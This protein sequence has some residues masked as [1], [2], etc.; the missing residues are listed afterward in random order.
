[1][2]LYLSVVIK[3]QIREQ[4]TIDASNLLAKP[5]NSVDSCV[6]EIPPGT[7]A[8]DVLTIQWPTIDEFQKFSSFRTGR[9]SRSS[10]SERRGLDINGTSSPV[11]SNGTNKDDTPELHV[12]FTIPPNFAIKKIKSQ[13]L[14][15]QAPWIST[16]RAAS[17]TLDSRQLRRIGIDTP[18]SRR[19]RRVEIRNWGEGNVK[20]KTCPIGSMYQV[21]ERSI[22]KAG[23]W[24]KLKNDEHDPEKVE[25][26]Q[27]W[28]RERGAEACHEDERID[29]YIDSLETFQ[30]DQFFVT[31]HQCNYN[32]DAAKQKMDCKTLQIETED[33]NT[34][35]TQKQKCDPARK[36]RHSIK[37]ST[38]IRN[39]FL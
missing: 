22:P 28:D 36:A 16:A 23:T 29:P 13:Y 4:D 30:K 33:G 19:S 15:L 5:S 35:E 26:D 37:P 11:K 31:L 32:F 6:V 24:A 17:A 3:K 25:C 20:R 7:K 21:S 27:M 14:R 34:S 8:G 10:P 2:Y 38:R 39:N 1:M 9:S 12:N 18:G